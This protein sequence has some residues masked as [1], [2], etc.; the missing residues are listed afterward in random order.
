MDQRDYW[1]TRGATKTFTHPVDFSWL[2]PLDPAARILDHGCGHGRVTAAAHAHGFTAVEGADPS[3]ALIARA[4]REHPGLT[5]HPLPE[6]RFPAAAFDAVLLIAVLTCVLTDEEQRSLIAGLARI[7][8]PGGLLYVSDLLR[9]PDRRYRPG[10]LFTTSDGAVCRHHTRAWLHD[11]LSERFT[12]TRTREIPVPTMN[13]NR[14]RA[15]QLLAT[16][17]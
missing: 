3:P 7:L 2:S 15:L 12:V 4:R 1:N 8:R 5:F 9:Q 16:R 11:L 10:G 13:G 17:A 14:A 6:T